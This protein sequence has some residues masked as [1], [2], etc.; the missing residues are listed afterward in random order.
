M[1]CGCSLL[2]LQMKTVMFLVLQKWLLFNT[3]KHPHNKLISFYSFW[4][5]MKSV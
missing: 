3:F 2:L 5:H 4:Q 1:T